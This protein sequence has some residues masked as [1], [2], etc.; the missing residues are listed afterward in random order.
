[1][2]KLSPHWSEIEIATLSGITSFDEM[3]PV[4][5]GILQRMFKPGSRI[6]QICGPMSTGGK[7]SLEA[8]MAYFQK[9]MD[10]A[11]EKGLHVFDQTPFQD[12]MI[13]LAAEHEA[14]R[15]YC[16]EIL[17]VF[18]R[19]I[20]KSGLISELM[21]LPDWESSVGSRWER[22]EA[23]ALGIAVSEYPAEWLPLLES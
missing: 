17:H 23:A 20:F 12:A 1:M 5:I 9:A 7:G 14:R 4:G 6:V 3:V 18:Y 13:R 21:F 22:E 10:V 11:S 16:V 8:N 19:G 2:K 15:E